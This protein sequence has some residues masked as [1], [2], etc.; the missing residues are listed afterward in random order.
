MPSLPPEGSQLCGAETYLSS[1]S[2][3]EIIR[4]LWNRMFH[5]RAHKSLP[6]VRNPV[7]ALPHRFAKVHF[8][9]IAQAGGLSI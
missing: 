5:Y 7:L 6:L 4:I 9:A 8:N 1:S 2:G 3:H